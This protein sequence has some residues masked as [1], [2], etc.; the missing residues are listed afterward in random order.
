MLKPGLY[1]KAEKYF[2]ILETVFVILVAVSL[3]LM[4]KTVPY[5]VYCVTASFSLLAIL[6]WLVAM[7]PNKDVPMFVKVT[8]KVHLM[9]LVLAVLSIMMKFK[10]DPESYSPMLIYVALVSVFAGFV[11]IM[12]SKIKF[13]YTVN[14]VSGVTRSLVYLL[15]LLW[16]C[17]L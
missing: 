14:F 11:M 3:F 6:Y 13:H 9:G 10:M 1:L 16:V 8:K 15:I 2:D 7:A 4:V 12:I 5:S 17:A